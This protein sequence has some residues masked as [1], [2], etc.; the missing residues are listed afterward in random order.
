MSGWLWAA[1]IGALAFVVWVSFVALRGLSIEPPAE[2]SQPDPTADRT[3][4]LARLAALR[5]YDT[6]EV[7]DACRTRLIEPEGLDPR[8][9]LVVWHG[10]SNCPAQFAEVAELIAD[11]GVRVLLPRMPRHGNRD[12]LTRDLLKLTTGELIAHVDACIDI[13]AG[14]G[15]PVWVAGLSAGGVLASWAAATRSEV[16]RIAIASPFVAPKGVPLPVVRLL[17][18]YP[19]LLPKLYVWW[20]PRKK[21][22]LGE[23]P[24]VYPGFPLPSM[25]PV[26]HLAETLFDGHLEVNHRLRR[27]VLVTN[28]GDFAIRRDA[29]QTFAENTFRDHADLFAEMTLDASLG[30]WHDFIDR[31]GAHHGPTEQVAEVFLSALGIATDPSAAGAIIAPIP[32]ADGSDDR[33]AVAL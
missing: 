30:W 1:L 23:S 25:V 24:Y 20:D 14:F 8:A 10:F 5:A 27:A 19:W 22:N 12:V 2:S 29:A 18:R 7:A 3:Q 28:P 11:G 32:R 26:L 16:T 15:A 6:E 31:H 9:T 33:A 17:V 21:E 4:A 13:A